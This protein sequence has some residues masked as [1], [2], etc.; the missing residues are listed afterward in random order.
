MKNLIIISALLSVFSMSAV[1]SDLPACP[2]DQIKRYHNCY[3]TY[4]NVNGE[5]YVGEWK[6]IR[7]HGQGTYTWA[8]GSKYVGEWKYGKRNGQGTYTNVNGDKYVGEWK[9]N[10][11]HGEGV[12]TKPDGSVQ[13]GIFRNNQYLGTKEFVEAERRKEE[14][15]RKRKEAKKMINDNCII[16]HLTGNNDPLL[17]NSVY[18]KCERISENPSMW[19]KWKYSD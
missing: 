7:H 5:T 18:N 2:K 14:A 12:L 11:R 3:G 19:Q 15:E 8:D 4:T 17:R 6:D 1:A 10:N 16:E 9:D 13:S